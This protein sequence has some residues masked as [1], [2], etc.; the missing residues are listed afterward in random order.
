MKNR[1]LFF[2]LILLFASGIHLD[3]AGAQTMVLRAGVAKTDIT[4]SENVF[5]GGYD[6]RTGPSTGVYGKIYVNALVFDNTIDR[7]LFLEANLLFFGSDSIRKRISEATGIPYVNIIAGAAHNHSAPLTGHQNDNTQWSGQLEEKVISTVKK[8]L[9]DLEAV[10]I[11]G[12]AGHSRIAMNRRK[13]MVDT[14]SYDTWDEN[15]TSQSYG[16]A[17]TDN[18]VKIRE[19]AGVIRLGA[20]P[21]GPID[22]EVGVFRIDRLSGEPKAVFINYACHGTSLGGRNTV[23]SPEWMGHMLE[24]VEANVPGVIGI[25]AQGAAGD[26]NPRFVGGLD[27]CV[28]NLENTARLGCEIGREAVRVYNS[29]VTVLPGDPRIRLVHEDIL[30]PRAYR[31]LSADFTHPYIAVPTTA[32]RIDEFTWVTFPGEMFHQIGQRI[33]SSTHSKYSYLVGYCG[34]GSGLVGYLPT[35]QAFSEGGYEPSSSRFDPVSENIYVA[36]VNKMLMR[37]Y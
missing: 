25:F 3:A 26:I 5:L 30:C 6:L 29:I 14:L 10:K 15:N 12:G 8:A 1:Y 21:E 17:K 4:P 19:F 28:D 24:Y 11:G 22:D 13:R 23:I 32:I 27:G 20:N 16:K 35:R 36:A 34:D 2:S 7:V 37:L 9:N 18:P 33:K 31:L